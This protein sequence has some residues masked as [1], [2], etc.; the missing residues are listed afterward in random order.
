MSR[1]LDMSTAE[2]GGRKFGGSG[3]AP[4]LACLRNGNTPDE[5]PEVAT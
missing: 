4:G 2:S 5:W 3:A 1:M